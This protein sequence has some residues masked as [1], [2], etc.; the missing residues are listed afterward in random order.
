MKNT[1]FIIPLFACLVSAPLFAM[2]DAAAGKEKS[3]SCA[4]CHG[5]DGNSAAPNFPKIAGQHA[6]Y[7]YKQLA[8]FKNGKRENATMAGLVASLSNADMQ[9]LAA[10]YASQT[11]SKGTTAEDQLAMGRMIYRAGNTTTGVSACAACHGPNGTG[12]PQANF[13]SLG[14]QHAAYTEDQL[15]QFSKSKRANDAGSMMR[16]IARKMSEAEMKAVAEYIQSLQ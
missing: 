6:G 14:G 10:Y 7:L 15:K 5:A 4:A 2:G 9:D 11:G 12:N 3:A 8:E 1:L 16:V 13:P